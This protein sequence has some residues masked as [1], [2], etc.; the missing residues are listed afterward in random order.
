M[1]LQDYNTPIKPTWCPGC[2][3]F[4]TWTAFK[5]AAA[6]E[7]WDSS[8]TALIADVGCHGHIA[9]YTNINALVGLHGRA[10]PAATGIKLANN[11]LNVFT[12]IGDGGCLAEGGNHFIHACRRNHDMVI[13]IHDN[14]I[15][16]LTTGQTSPRS[17]HGFISKSTP[18]GNIDM[19]LNPMAIAIA[20]GA[21]FV[22]RGLFSDIAQLTQLFID[23]NNHKGIAIVDVLQACP[24]FNKE[25]TP[26]YFKQNTYYLPKDYKVY[27]KERAFTK[28]L[29][30]GEKQIPLGIF[31]EDNKQ[32]S[33]EAQI[34][35]IQTHSVSENK[36][37]KR[38]VSELYKRFI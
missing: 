8:N 12:F 25:Y 17:P 31:Y 10:V 5:M 22:A 30:W 16:G 3:N 37:V 1:N 29:E 19:P 21:T 2:G 27:N 28:A 23:A 4:G 36:P 24:S 33:Y 14:A 32:L 34:P 7:G 15:Y 18:E 13:I 6:K 9:N 20:S 26:E 35:F 11:K 38:D